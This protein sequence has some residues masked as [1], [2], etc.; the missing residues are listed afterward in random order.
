MFLTLALKQILC[1]ISIV[2][3][4][5]FLTYNGGHM[6]ENKTRHFTVALPVDLYQEIEQMAKS[7]FRSKAAQIVI[8]LKKALKLNE[9]QTTDNQ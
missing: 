5:L 7:E 9:S 8:L 1:Y 3:L 2:I 4:K 6:I